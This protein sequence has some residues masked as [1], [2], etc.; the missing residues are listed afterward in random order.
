MSYDR[1]W[2]TWQTHKSGQI[3]VKQSH[4]VHQTL[5]CWS[6]RNASNL[7]RSNCVVCLTG[8]TGWSQPI[9]TNYLRSHNFA[10]HSLTGYLL[11]LDY[12]LAFIGLQPSAS[13]AFNWH[14]TALLDPKQIHLTDGWGVNTALIFILMCLE[15]YRSWYYLDYYE[16]LTYIRW[17]NTLENTLSPKFT[18][19]DPPLF[20]WATQAGEWM[21]NYCQATCLSALCQLFVSS[22]SALCQLFVSS[23][24]AVFHLFVSCLSAVCQLFVSCLSAVCQLFVSCLSAVCQLFVSSLSAVCQLFVSGL[25][26]FCHL[27]VSCLS[28]FT[29]NIFSFMWNQAVCIKSMGRVM[30]HLSPIPG[31]ARTDIGHIRVLRIKLDLQNKKAWIELYPLCVIGIET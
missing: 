2:E 15:L 29:T 21:K 14:K 19:A 4:F 16:L 13:A 17:G 11:I 18:V 8:W 23:L 12:R 24:T 22:L 20:P 26:A 9:M 10:S 28:S 6:Q 3:G 1:A 31:T 25:S 30:A 7:S 5:A 27:F